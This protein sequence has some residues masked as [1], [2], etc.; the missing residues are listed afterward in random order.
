MRRA[1]RTAAGIRTNCFSDTVRFLSDTLKLE[2]AHDDKKKEF[3]R[4]RLPSGEVLEV[5]GP[6]HLWHPF[7]NAPDWE[8]I[9]ADVRHRN[10]SGSAA[11]K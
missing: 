10:T 7:A 3:V 5:F 11:D 8:I 2:I 4:F 6:K 9:I 1:P